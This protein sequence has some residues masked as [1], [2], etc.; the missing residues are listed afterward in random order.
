MLKGYM[1]YYTVECNDEGEVYTEAG[2]V[3]VTGFVEAMT[4]LEEYYGRC[5][6]VIK[7]LELL[8]A[9][10]LTMSPE[11]AEKLLADVFI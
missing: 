11:T 2:F 10:I 6:S 9:S 5:L 7:H 1:A 8:D 4:M 3:P